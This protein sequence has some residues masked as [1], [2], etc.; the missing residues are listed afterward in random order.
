MSEHNVTSGSSSPEKIRWQKT[1]AEFLWSYIFGFLLYCIFDGTVEHVFRALMR[2]EQ[3]AW[4][5]IQLEPEKLFGALTISIGWMVL[6]IITNHNKLLDS[7]NKLINETLPTIPQDVSQFMCKTGASALRETLIEAVVSEG[8]KS[9]PPQVTFHGYALE[10][11]HQMRSFEEELAPAVAVFADRRLAVL[12]TTVA[13]LKN[14]K[15]FDPTIEGCVQVEMSKAFANRP[16][17]KS[18]FMTHRHTAVLMKIG[19]HHSKNS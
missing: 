4:G 15:A 7:L 11:L 17:K 10:F 1:V 13:N 19:V 18:F 2:K 5:I 3:W 9:I 12:K 14:D 16:A 6:R 8:K